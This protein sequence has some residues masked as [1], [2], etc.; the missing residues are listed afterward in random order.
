MYGFN[1]PVTHFVQLNLSDM[2]TALGEDEVKNILSSFVC[3]LNRDVENFMRHKACEF[4]KRN[5][6]KTHV[7]FWSTDD[8]TEKELVGYY[9]IAVR[10]IRVERSIINS[11]Q[12]RKLREHG[13][14]DEK[15][16]QYIVSAPL[17]G[18]LGKNFSNGNDTL[19][20]G[21][22]LLNLA[23]EKIRGVQKEVGGR[24]AYLECED[25]DKLTT[26]YERNNFRVFGKRKLDGDETDIRGEYLVQMFTML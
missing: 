5:F 11:K 8:E 4:S 12:A 24:F 25:N 14:F 22:E 26:F 19:I 1:P 21:E 6:S 15:N 2:I 3:P 10:T 13:V 17:I 20:S 23:M 18:Q 7:V 16:K 9:T